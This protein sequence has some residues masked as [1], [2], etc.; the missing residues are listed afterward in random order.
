MTPETF[1]HWAVVIGLGSGIVLFFLPIDRWISNLFTCKSTRLKHL[2]ER[3]TNIEKRLLD[4]QKTSDK[5]TESQ[6]QTAVR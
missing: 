2:E 6:D 5:K 4:G 1:F 3:V